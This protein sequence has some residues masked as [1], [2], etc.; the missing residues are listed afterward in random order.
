MTKDSTSGCWFIALSP[1]VSQTFKVF[2]WCRLTLGEVSHLLYH[3]GHRLLN[4]ST[5]SHL[6]CCSVSF[7]DSGSK[8]LGLSDKRTHMEK[9]KKTL[10]RSFHFYT[11]D[12]SDQT[13]HF[14][15]HKI[16]HISHK[17]QLHGQF[18]FFLPVLC[19]SDV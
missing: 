14:F 5:S 12:A 2:W 10:I 16:K 4:L 7:F 8:L 6:C 11:Y 3:Q 9:K 17:I 13:C 18:F 1:F 19:I 15:L